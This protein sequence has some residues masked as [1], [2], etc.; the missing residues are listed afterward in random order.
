MM[1]KAFMGAKRI[2]HTCQRFAKML[3]NHFLVGN[4]VGHLT[5]AIHIIGKAEKLGRDI[6]HG[7]KRAAD[8]G[9][10]RDFAKGADM[11]QT[12]RTITG[13]KKDIALFRRLLFIPLDQLAGF[14]KGPDV[15]VKCGISKIG[16]HF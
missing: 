9:R 3:A 15:A 2:R 8:I 6:A 4:V 5:Q 14:L 7:F 10:T 16:C 13:F 11:R 12:R 1:G